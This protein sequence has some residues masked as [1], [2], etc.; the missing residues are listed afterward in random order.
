MGELAPRPLCAASWT[1]AGGLHVGQTGDSLAVLIRH[2]RRAR[3]RARLVFLPHRNVD[4]TV[5][6]CL[7]LTNLHAASTDSWVSPELDAAAAHTLII[8]SDGTWEPLQIDAEACGRNLGDALERL[9][10]RHH[11]A[12]ETARAV[13]DA[14]VE[15]G[16]DDNATV[17]VARMPAARHLGDPRLT[18]EDRASLTALIEGDE[19][20]DEMDASGDTIHGND[21]A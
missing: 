9:A 21:P 12:A 6:S 14:A 2:P 13:L 5:A 1:L 4:G 17:A 19:F 16:L 8:L 10:D 11:T 7:G 18:S 3:P 15:I 20:L